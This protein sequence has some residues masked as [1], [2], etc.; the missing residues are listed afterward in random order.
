MDIALVGDSVANVRL[1]Y[2]NTLPVTVEEMLHH[3]KASARGVEQAFLVADM[4]FLS[5]EAA[6]WEAAKTAG[7]F[8][9]EGKAQAVKLEGGKRVATSIKAILNANVPVMGHLGLVPQ[10]VHKMGG[11]HVQGKKPAEAQEIFKD[12]KLLQSLGV[13]SIVLEGIPSPLAKKI[14]RALHIPTIGIGAGPHCDGQIL[15]LDDMLGL[16]EGHSP[17][18]VKHFASLRPTMDKAI[19][20]YQ[21]EVESHRFPTQAQSY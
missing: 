2:P 8:V 14:T 1:G 3:V 9:K 12:A 19:R 5:Y 16:T 6:P 10:S 4:P 20:Q 7:R 17:K 15:V 18:F 13:F 21:I 11:Y